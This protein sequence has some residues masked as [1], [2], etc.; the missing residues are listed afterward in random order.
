MQ[1]TPTVRLTADFS[2]ESME[3]RS[4]YDSIFKVLKVKYD[5]TRILYPVKLLFKNEGK[6]KAFYDKQQKNAF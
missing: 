3:A 6:I 5:H 1:G 4:H 2:S